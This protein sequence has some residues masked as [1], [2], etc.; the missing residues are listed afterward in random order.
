[1][2]SIHISPNLQMN[3]PPDRVCAQCFYNRLSIGIVCRKSNRNHFKSAG[4]KTVCSLEEI[5]NRCWVHRQRISR[6]QS[7]PVNKVMVVGGFRNGMVCEENGTER[8]GEISRS[9]GQI[10]PPWGNTSN[11]DVNVFE[12]GEDVP[13]VDLKSSSYELEPKLQFLEERNEEVLSR[14]ILVLSRCNK[15]RSALELF[16]SMDASGL[17]ANPHACNSLLS[18]LLRKEFFSDALKVFRMMK[19]EMTSGHTYSLILKAIAT[20]E[21]CDSALKMFMELEKEGTLVNVF[22]AIAYNT[23]I[24]ICVKANNWVQAERIWKSLKANGHSATEVTYNLLVSIFVRCGECELAFDAYNEMVQNGLKPSEDMMQ[25]IISVCTKEGKCVLAHSTLQSMLRIGLNPNVATYNAMINSL[26][27]AG[28]IGL[29]FEVFGQMRSSGYTPDAYTWNALLSSL[30]RDNRYMDALQLFESIKRNKSTQLSSHL[31]NTALLSCQRLGSWERSLQILWEMETVGVPVSTESYNLVIGACEAARKPE[32]AL[33]VYAQMVHMKCT[34]NTFTYLSLIR[35]CVWG[36][37]WSEVKDILDHVPAD[38][39]LYNAVIHGM[40]LQGEIISAK[41]IYMK[42]RE[43]G[44]KPDGKTRSL[45]LQ[46]LKRDSTKK[47]SRYSS[48]RQ[49]Q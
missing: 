30:N 29:A 33:Q 14:R 3:Y 2:V 27:K 28:E 1:M 4:V 23:M 40:C 7:I 42:M 17:Q 32:I 26:G 20:V 6:R 49:R 35:A 15:V 16:M 13:I 24:S 12:T 19:K 46:N 37:L 45:M 47:H 21:G 31:F 44:L 22:D 8:V 43:R 10:L 34:P 18:C 48:H 9:H 11:I 41:K 38:V 25:A 36:S 39:S 5:C